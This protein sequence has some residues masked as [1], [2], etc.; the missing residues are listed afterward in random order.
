MN[1]WT[2]STAVAASFLTECRPPQPLS[3]QIR[4][5]VRSHRFFDLRCFAGE[6]PISEL[7]IVAMG[8]EQGIRP[9]RPV[10]FGS[11]DR[12]G[13]PPV[14][15]LAGELEDPARHRHGNPSAA[16]SFTSG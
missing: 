13:E 5:A 2:G 11:G 3:R 12:I 16:S 9:V 14:V 1:W 15:G 7:G 10:Q 4:Q 8:I 6:K